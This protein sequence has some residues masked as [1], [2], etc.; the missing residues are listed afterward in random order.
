MADPSLLSIL[1]YEIAR[2]TLELQIASDFATFTWNNTDYNCT[3]VLTQQDYLD[4]GGLAPIGDLVLTVSL[5]DLPVPGPQ[6]HDA[7]T[8]QSVDYEIQI[9]KQSPGGSIVFTC[10]RLGRGT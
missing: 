4:P 10:W 7:V 6:L 8:F 1:E 3:F 5:A 9:I 2:A